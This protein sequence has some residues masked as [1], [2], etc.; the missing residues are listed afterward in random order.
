MLYWVSPG[1]GLREPGAEPDRRPSRAA[2]SSRRAS[3]G[4]RRPSPTAASR[5]ARAR[6][7][8]G[9]RPTR[10]P[11]CPS[12]FDSGEPRW[13]SQTVSRM[14]SVNWRYSDCQFSMHRGPEVRRDARSAR[15]RSR[16]SPWRSLLLVEVGVARDRLAAPARPGTAAGR[17]STG[18]CRAGS[19]ASV[20]HQADGREERDPTDDQDEVDDE[21]RAHLSPPARSR[22]AGSGAVGRHPAAEILQPS[23]PSFRKSVPPSASVRVRAASSPRAVTATVPPFGSSSSRIASSHGFFSCCS[24]FEAV[25]S[26]SSSQAAWPSSGLERGVE[27]LG[28]GGG[29]AV[30]VGRSR[31]RQ[32]AAR[33]GTRT[34]RAWVPRHAL[35]CPGVRTRQTG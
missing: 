11:P 32:A 8:S 1:H 2:A 5:A 28:H 25:S 18:C 6:R 15:A 22:R 26:L 23:G 34:R 13:S 29:V 33:A 24:S 35:S 31:R 7:P 30:A 9:P 17:R 14:N 12:S 21:H 27:A 16:G 19:G 10:A 3:A 20:V 4:A